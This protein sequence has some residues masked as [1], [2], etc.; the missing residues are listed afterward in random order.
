MSIQNSINEEY[1]VLLGRLNA[2]PPNMQMRWRAF[3]DIFGYMNR[4]KKIALLK[5]FLQ[6]CEIEFTQDLYNTRFWDN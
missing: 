2:L 6:I 5:T 1:E 3:E 4:E